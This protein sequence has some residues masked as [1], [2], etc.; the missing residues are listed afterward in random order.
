M[1]I[2][3]AS[4]SVG[5]GLATNPVFG[6]VCVLLAT[7]IFL[8]FCSWAKGHQISGSVKKLIFILTGLGL[9]V[10]NLA[11]AKGNALITASGDWN[12]AT[13]ALGTS[14]LWVFI[15]AFALMSDSKT[16]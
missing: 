12:G 8:K 4:S 16:E 10:F 14:L 2:I 7:Y 11:Y 13:V 1:L 3:F 5:G 15:F 9:V 6:I